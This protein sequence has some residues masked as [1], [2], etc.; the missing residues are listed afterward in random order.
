MAKKSFEEKLEEYAYNGKKDGYKN[1]D[2]H[3]RGKL[4]DK[5]IHEKFGIDFENS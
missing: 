4:L 2:A 5:L 1:Y 3:V